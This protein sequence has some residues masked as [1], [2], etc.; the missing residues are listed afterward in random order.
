VD[1]AADGAIQIVYNDTTSQFHGAHLLMTRQLSGP[2]PF[3]TT[4]NKAAPASPVFDPAGD[5]QVPHYGPTGAGPNQPQLDFKSVAVN[6]IDANTIRVRMTVDNLASM[7][8]PPGKTSAFWIT[9]FQALSKNDA[10][11]G[12]AY[13]IFYVGAESVGG[14]APVFFAGSPNLVG[15][16]VGCNGTTPGTCKVVQYPTEFTS[17]TTQTLVGTVSGNTFCIDLP[18]SLFGANRPIG[19]TLYNVTAFSGGRNNAAEDIYTEGDSTRSFDF[20]LGTTS[21]AACTAPQLVCTAT[22]FALSTAGAV[23]TASSTAM[24]RN[25]SAGSAIDGEH[26]GV[27]WENGGGWNDDTRDQWPDTLE[28]AFSGAR[29][30]NEVRVYTLQNNFHNPVEPDA[31]TPAD[32]YGIRDFDVQYWD[33]ANWVNVP[34]GHVIGND[35]AMR[36]FTFPDI[37]TSKIRVVV[38]NGRVYYSR[39]VE[40]EAFGCGSQ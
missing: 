34:G 35:K 39:I 26:R 18:L 6:Q 29:T 33:G 38:N 36:V 17:L 15:A 4:L 3:G 11:T 27:N 19:N 9:R 5:A 22:N 40:I 14:A 30:I 37:L 24:S 21:A 25:Y 32:V 16:P 23:A 13:R 8:P 7:L 28:V 31:N 12:E 10:G 2:T 1:I 20:A